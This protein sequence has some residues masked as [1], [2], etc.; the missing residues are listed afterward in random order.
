MCVAA[1]CVLV[2]LYC[3]ESPDIVIML[4]SVFLYAGGIFVPAKTGLSL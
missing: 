3:T 4:V 2:S 1:L